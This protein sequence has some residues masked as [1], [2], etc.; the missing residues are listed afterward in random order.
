M[1]VLAIPARMYG[2]A[3]GLAPSQR[4]KIKLAQKIQNISLYI[5]L[6]ERLRMLREERGRR[7]R[8][9]IARIM[10]TTPPSL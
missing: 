10:K 2:A 9:R 7:R 5:G 6:K 8:M 4:R 1:E 3:M